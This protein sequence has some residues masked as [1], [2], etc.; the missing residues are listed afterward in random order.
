MKETMNYRDRRRR[1]ERKRRS[2][3]RGKGQ[4]IGATRRD[5]VWW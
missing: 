2:K 3:G 4:E 1:R 5:W